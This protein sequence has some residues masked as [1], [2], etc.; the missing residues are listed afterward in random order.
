MTPLSNTTERVGRVIGVDPG[1][2]GAIAIVDATGAL[3]CVE[4]MPI[5]TIKGKAKIDVHGL[6][7]IIAEHAANGRGI[8]EQVGAM[9]KQGVSS[10]FTFGFAAG[11]VHGAMGALAIPLDTVTPQKWKAHFRLSKDKDAARQLA[12]RRWPHGPFTLKKH[13]GRAEAALIALYAVETRRLAV[14]P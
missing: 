1:N 14:T 5:F 6:G 2:T 3:I 7:R 13:H 8:I 10:V 4:D 9:P 12:T 11:A